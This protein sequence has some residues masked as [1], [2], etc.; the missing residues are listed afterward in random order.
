MLNLG[1]ERYLGSNELGILASSSDPMDPM[2]VTPVQL[3]Y[4]PDSS[5]QAMTDTNM[6]G[7]GA[8]G[9]DLW[10]FSPMIPTWAG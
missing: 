8:L 7:M 4:S 9:G 1:P 2:E 5:A 10:D 6:F 3:G